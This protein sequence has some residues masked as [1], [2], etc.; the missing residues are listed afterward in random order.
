MFGTQDVEKAAK[1]T[2]KPAQTA[3]EKHRAKQAQKL[4]QMRGTSEVR[5]AKFVCVI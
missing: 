5:H 1:K 2:K 3:A 4:D